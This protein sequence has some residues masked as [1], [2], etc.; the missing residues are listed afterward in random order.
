MSN[1]ICG[2]HGGINLQQSIVLQLIIA[3]WWL[4]AADVNNHEAGVM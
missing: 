4:V 1:A 3:V 2:E